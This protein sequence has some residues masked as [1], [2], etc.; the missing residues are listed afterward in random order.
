VECDGL[1][2]STGCRHAEDRQAGFG[3]PFLRR[4]DLDILG[5]GHSTKIGNELYFPFK[6]IPDKFMTEAMV[7]VNLLLRAD[8]DPF[9]LLGSIRAQVAGPTLD[10]PMYSVRTM[11][12]I[13]SESLA[14]RRFTMLLLVIFASTALALAMVGIYGVMSYAVGR[15]THELGVRMALG[16]SQQTVLSLV[17]RQGMTLAASGAIVGLAGA[18]V[19]TRFMAG[20]LF[21]VRPTDPWTLGAVALLLGGIALSACC[22]PAMRAAKVDPMVALR[23]E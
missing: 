6:Q 10:Q 18:L 9:S 7:G 14:E 20:L 4:E 22:V 16:A 21:G 5:A 2:Q 1:W 3:W 19:L 11:E 12:Q 23:Y 17:L 8:R 13:I 15:C